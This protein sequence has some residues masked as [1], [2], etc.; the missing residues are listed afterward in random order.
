[1]SQPEQAGQLADAGAIL[2]PHI[3]IR[4]AELE[5]ERRELRGI[6]RLLISKLAEQNVAA[7]CGVGSFV[8][9]GES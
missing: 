7:L 4:L 2:L 6:R 1:M 3:G 9:L 5:A 8:D